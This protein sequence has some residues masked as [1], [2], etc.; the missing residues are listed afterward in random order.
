MFDYETLKLI[1]WALIGVLL[2]GFAITDGMDMGV[3]TLL[4]FIA[5]NDDQRRV[6]INTI[7]AHWDGNQ[8]WFITAGGALFA[9]WPS[10]YATAFSSFYF[11]MMLVLFA[12]FL[13]PVG[14]D[15]R[16]KIDDLRWRHSWDWALFVGS[17]IPPLVFG[18]AFG[19]LFLAVPFHFDE[20]LRV[21]YTGSFFELFHPFALLCGVVS[22]AMIIMHGAT[23]LQLR[24][25]PIIA[26]RARPIVRNSCL[27]LLISFV[28]AGLYLTQIDGY[29]L[30]EIGD[31]NGQPDI[32]NKMVSR[33]TGA[34]LNNY[35]LMPWT[36]V[37]PIAAIGFMLSAAFFSHKNRPGFALIASS[38][39]IA[40]IIAT[41]GFSLF[42]FI[43]PSSSFLSSSL[44]MWDAVSSEL[45]LNIMLFVV[46]ILLPTVISYT[47]WCYYK[48]WRTVTLEEIK[49]NSHSAY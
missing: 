28:A 2:I 20:F 46:A 47:F 25:D 13:R 35:H 7:G 39:M 32:L 48:M 17:S 10:V 40:A 5:K 14:F 27:V 19:N 6:V 18:V 11:A 30:I 21:T 33:S 42:P 23:W 3:G 45:T 29:T 4:P 49:D 38:K 8:V 34:W 12:L 15:Y 9:A 26:T 44:T 36:I 37:F 24:A 41:A 16:S 31:T 43:L 22:V 1:W